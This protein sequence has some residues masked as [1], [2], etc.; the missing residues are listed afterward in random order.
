MKRLLFAVCIIVALSIGIAVISKGTGEKEPAR[1]NVPVSATAD[2]KTVP[3]ETN[4]VVPDDITKQKSRMH[5]RNHS[6]KNIDCKS[7]HS[8]EYPTKQDACLVMC[9]R[10]N[11]SVHHSP[12]E[13]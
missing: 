6:K 10:S 8:C 9:P 2:R 11:I 1:T 3:A 4:A 5:D 13:E 12:E 7:C